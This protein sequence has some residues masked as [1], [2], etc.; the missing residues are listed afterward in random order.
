LR[1]LGG[2]ASIGL[3]INKHGNVVG[4]SYV[5]GGNP[6]VA[7]L[8]AFRWVEGL[9]M[10]DLGALPGGNVAEGQGINSSGLV[11]GG[12]H[13]S[14][15]GDV[16]T[17]AFLATANGALIDLGTMG[18]PGDFSYAWDVNDRGQVTGE[19]VV[20][21]GAEGGNAHAFVW[22]SASGMKDVGTL[23]GTSSVG[24]A[25]NDSGQVAGES[26][27]S[28]GS[29]IAFRFTTGA[30]LVGLGTLG[31]SK[32]SAYGINEGGEVVGES[33]T[34]FVV[35]GN[36]LFTSLTLFG[37][38]AFRW[39]VGSGMMDLGHLGGGF[40]SARAINNKGVIVGIGSLVGG[41]LRAFRWTNAGG[42]IDLNTLLPSNSGWILT[43][44][45]DVNDAGQVTGAGYHNGRRRAFRLNPP[46]SVTES[47]EVKK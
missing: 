25:I 24:R 20:R 30:G 47:E 1:T 13:A 23:G 19:A 26:K 44:A 28:S 22:T 46:A 32:S 34:G 7:G 6:H 27:T 3:G 10:V 5:A 43:E 9:G 2:I 41:E 4:G 21:H 45:Y 14:V 12:S 15:E 37:T 11:V 8:H 42:M 29:T 35:K 36:A 40:S 39:R 16:V 31:G 17:H 38:H 18:D 33:E